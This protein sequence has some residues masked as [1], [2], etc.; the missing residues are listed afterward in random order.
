M[1]PAV[2]DWVTA[3]MRIYHEEQFGSVLPVVAFDD[4]QVPIQRIRNSEYG[5]QTSIYSTDRSEIAYFNNAVSTQ[6]G[7]I[8]INSMCQRG[9]DEVAFSATK[10]SAVGTLSIEAAL[11]KFSK[12]RVAAENPTNGKYFLVNEAG[13]TIYLSD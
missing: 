13:E 1:V 10:W 4:I 3:D 9:P 11:L 12:D 6:L 5:Q 7:R 2:L 8:N